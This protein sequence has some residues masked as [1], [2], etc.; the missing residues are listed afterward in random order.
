MSGEESDYLSR[1]PT[2]SD[3]YSLPGFMEKRGR[4]GTIAL[5][6]NKAGSDSKDIYEDYKVRNQ[7]ETMIDAMKNTLM[8][9]TSYMQNED[10]FNGWMFINF[11]ALQ[12]YYKIYMLLKEKK[13]IN[14]Y[15]PK[16]LLMF[17]QHVRK[18]KINGTWITGEINGNTKKLIEKLGLKPIT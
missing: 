12:F 18:V 2:H 5:L 13:L 10:A 3:K 14:N 7:V 15:S 11:I 1:I 17:L 9:D 8:A 4:F 6:T 16:D